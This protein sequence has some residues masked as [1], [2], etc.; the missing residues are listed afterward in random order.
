MCDRGSGVA[1][2]HASSPRRTS[3]T[4]PRA[5]IE[6]VQGL[7]RGR[8]RRPAR[9]RPGARRA[10]R[11]PGRRAWRASGAPRSARRA[12]GGPRDARVGVEPRRPCSIR[13]APVRWARGSHVLIPPARM[14]PPKPVLGGP[15]TRCRCS[16]TRRRR[17]RGRVLVSRSS[18]VRVELVIPDS[19]SSMLTTAR[20]SEL[21]KVASSRRASGRSTSTSQPSFVVRLTTTSSD[22]SA[23]TTTEP[24]SVSTVACAGRGP[25]DR[26]RRGLRR[27]GRRDD[28]VVAWARVPAH[29]RTRWTSKPAASGPVRRPASHSLPSG[30]RWPS[31]RSPWH[32]R[33]GAGSRL[34]APA[35]A[36]Q[37]PAHDHHRRAEHQHHLDVRTRGRQLP[38]ACDGRIDDGAW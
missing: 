18:R 15:P 19:V 25:V 30:R 13:P 28:V 20:P 29:R 9:G 33:T 37:R 16:Y 12:T 3:G 26:R 35:D 22:P 34:G 38:A 2:R 23:A 5:R 31:R 27:L 32:R 14:W 7:Q 21:V 8:A 10:R 36:R 6:A 24:P 17:V 11:T 4:T 1:A